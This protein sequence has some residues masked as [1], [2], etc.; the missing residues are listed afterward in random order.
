[1]Y[2]RSFFIVVGVGVG[3]EC[4]L[5]DDAILRHIVLQN[6]RIKPGCVI[7]S[8]SEVS[9]KLAGGALLLWGAILH[10][11]STASE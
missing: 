6:D 1:M 3:G 7:L 2:P 11:S 4:R 10:R 9:H 5:G 8:A